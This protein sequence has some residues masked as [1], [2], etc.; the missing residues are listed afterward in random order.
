M[1]DL[2]GLSTIEKTEKKFT[3]EQLEEI[4]NSCYD[5][6]VFE[7]ARELD[8]QFE[9]VD[10]AYCGEWRSDEEF[11]ENLIED[12]EPSIKDLPP[13]IYIDWERTAR[14]IMMDYG[15]DNGH[16]FRNL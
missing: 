11:V 6:E 7:A 5:V 10:E 1:T 3:D 13:Y 8:V 14:D 16:Y 15:E 12:T 4:E 9:D 2:V